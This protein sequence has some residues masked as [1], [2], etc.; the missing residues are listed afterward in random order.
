V[1]ASLEELD[2]IIE[3]VADQAVRLIDAARPDIATELLQVLRLTESRVRLAQHGLHEVHVAA[4]PS[5]VGAQDPPPVP[6][7]CTCGQGTDP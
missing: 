3:D 7:S 2:A 4:S 6:P 1:V 5:E